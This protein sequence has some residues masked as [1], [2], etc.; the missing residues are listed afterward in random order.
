[1]PRYQTVSFQQYQ[2]GT[3]DDQLVMFS[4]PAKAIASWAGIPR[5]GWNIRMLYQ[6]WITQSREQELVGF[7]NVAS[8]R[9]KNN[10]FIL[11]PTALTIAIREQAAIEEGQIEL[12]Y[13]SPLNPSQGVLENLQT[14]AGIVIP[15]IES[16]L[17]QTQRDTFEQFKAQPLVELP[18]TEHDL[19]LIHI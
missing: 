14:I 16:R 19:S 17:S 12:E 2:S 18:D 10:D 7:W 8:T 1:M 6:R 15:K 11:G 5:K 13:E 3:N 9:D 4:A